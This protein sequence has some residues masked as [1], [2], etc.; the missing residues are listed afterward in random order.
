MKLFDPNP[1]LR[2][3]FC[4]THPDDEIS[5][6][7]WMKR[8]TQSGADVWASWSVSNAIREAE[9]RAVMEQLGVT[10]EKLFF[11]QFPDGDLC[12]YVGELTHSLHEI[13][14]KI[15]PDRIAVGAFECGHLD[16]D[17]TNFSVY[18]AIKNIS[19]SN[20]I[21]LEI[22]FYYT[23]LTR[24]PVINR[25]ADPEGEEILF[26]AQE[27]R[28]LKIQVSK[29]YP[30]QNIGKLLFWYSIYGWLKL[31]PPQLPCTERLRL[32][33]HDNYSIPNL[34]FPLRDKVQAS[35]KWKR[36]LSAIHSKL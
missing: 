5:I 16:H 18:Q 8:L 19:Q 10:Q 2:W 30:S 4:F 33:T 34:P 35:S 22:P 6:C 9:A 20:L 12:D 21:L 23:Y 24:I 32:H 36:W 15:H 29:S 31:K 27:E 3:L 14:T 7:A 1:Q 25:F 17:S 13:V 11:F 28:N 26:L